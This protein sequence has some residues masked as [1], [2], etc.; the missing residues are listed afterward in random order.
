MRS[1]LDWA[2]VCALAATA[3]T[4]LFSA[5]GSGAVASDF[6]PN[7]QTQMNPIE[8]APRF[9]A[10]PLVQPLPAVAS[11]LSQ[12]ASDSAS[13]SQLVAK[14]AM[15]ENLSAEMR[16]LAS[17]IYFEARG[18]SLEGQLAVGQVVINRTQS[19]RFPAS[20]CG[21]VYQRSQFSFVRGGSMPSVHES[22]HDWRKAVAIAQ[23][24]TQDSWSTPADN[25]LFFHATSVSPRWHLTKLAKLDNHIFYR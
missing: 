8:Q 11:P 23:I 25:A 5:Q 14:Q 24:A 22:S 20:N 15:P 16:C 19:G 9:V 3:I 10:E 6:G 2:S 18:E 17:A 4:A 13:L 12:D 7:L 21:V 1:K